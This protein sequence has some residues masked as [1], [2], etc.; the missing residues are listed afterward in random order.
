MTDRKIAH[1][2][3]FLSLD[4]VSEFAKALYISNEVDVWRLGQL[5]EI[6]KVK[7]ETRRFC[8]EYEECCYKAYEVVKREPHLSWEIIL[9][10]INAVFL[11]G[12]DDRK[13]ERFWSLA[14]ASGSQSDECDPG[15]SQ[16]MQGW[17]SAIQI[18]LSNQQAIYSSKL[19]N[20]VAARPIQWD[21]L[22][23]DQLSLN[24]SFLGDKIDLMI[25]Y[26]CLVSEWSAHGELAFE[27]LCA[28]HRWGKKRAEAMGIKEWD[29]PFPGSWNYKTGFWC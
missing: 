7:I 5:R 1:A 3:A 9:E 8:Y 18:S 10:W 23:L 12:G 11:S 29:V 2:L 27:D 17:L 4:G 28:L 22:V 26:N 13:A 24:Q 6:L 19:L 21:A 14:V 25:R 16:S 15:F 20:L